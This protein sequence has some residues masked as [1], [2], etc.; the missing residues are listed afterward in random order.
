MD[1]KT[2]A[3]VSLFSGCGGFD[4]GLEHSGGKVI[5]SYDF[6]PLACE[7]YERVMGLPI[8]QADLTRIDPQTMPDADGIIGGPSCQAFSEA[9]KYA[10]PENTKNMWPATLAIVRAKCPQWF[11]FENVPGMLERHA[12]YFRWVIR[13]F[14]DT[15]YRVDYRKL[16]SADY[17]VPQSRE[18]VF[19]AGRLDGQS[20]N[21]PTP[22]HSATADMFSKRW[23]SWYEAL[24]QGWSAVAEQGLMPE[25][26]ARP[27]Y[28]RIPETAMVNC[29]DM[30]KPR[31]HRD[32]CE[33]AYT[34]TT[35]CV[36]R[37]RIVIDGTVYRANT[38]AMTRMQTLPDVPLASHVI[39]NAVPP[40]MAAALFDA[41]TVRP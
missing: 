32:A 17:G 26:T 3:V 37:T 8:Q 25:W 2:D 31:L 41:M 30:Y 13:Q 6:D 18:R 21:W 11:L 16:N 33:P 7:G 15:G 14:E 20:W 34:L 38:L 1:L 19:I 22:T 35:E 4:K 36:K 5:A 27:K 39:G 12:A 9:N 23:V 29:K 28:Q 40:K 10:S 24:P